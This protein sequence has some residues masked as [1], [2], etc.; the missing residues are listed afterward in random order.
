MG[1]AHALFPVVQA[2]GLAWGLYWGGLRY[3]LFGI[4]L[5][6]RDFPA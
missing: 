3:R 4:L 6:P 5:N 2:G 1:S